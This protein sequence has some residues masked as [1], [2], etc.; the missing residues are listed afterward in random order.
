[1]LASPFRGAMIASSCVACWGILFWM[2]MAYPAI[3]QQ[4]LSRAAQ[5]PAYLGLGRAG[6]RQPD[7]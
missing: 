3:Q 6:F 2:F 4:L 5:F 1:M 7:R